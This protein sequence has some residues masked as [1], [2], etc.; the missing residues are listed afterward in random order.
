MVEVPQKMGYDRATSVFSP[1]GRLLQVEYAKTAVN[2]GALALGIVCKDSVLLM[3]DR[4]LGSKLMTKD[5]VKK[6][7]KIDDHVIATASGLISDARV[8]VK[9][10]RIKSQQNKLIYGKEIDIESLIKYV[11]DIE[12]LY[13]QYGGIRPF[14]ISF[15]IAGIDS[16]PRL[17]MTEPSGI[18]FGYRARA[19]GQKSDEANKL[20]EKKYKLGL[21]LNE[22][23]ELAKSVFKKVLGKEYSAERIEAMTVTPKG[24]EKL[25]V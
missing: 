6:V 19:I 9:K 16:K 12:Q 7:L 1:D 2:K 18:Y 14:G 3:A 8:L 21:S 15:L 23:V 13:T 10:C 4:R 11:A 17:F 25:K 24:I 5:S 22:G 20:L